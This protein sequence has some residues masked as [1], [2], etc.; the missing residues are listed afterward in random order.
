MTRFWFVLGLAV[1]AAVVVGLAVGLALTGRPGS[2]AVAKDLATARMLDA[3]DTVADREDCTTSADEE[4]RQK[5]SAA[6]ASA[7]A[8]GAAGAAA[9]ARTATAEKAKDAAGAAKARGEA[10]VADAAQVTALADGLTRDPFR[11]GRAAQ[12]DAAIGRLD[13][14]PPDRVVALCVAA[15]RAARGGLPDPA[16]ALAGRLTIPGSRSPCLFADEAVALAKVRGSDYLRAA[17][18]E[19]AQGDDDAARQ[20]AARALEADSSLSAA[21]DALTD[22]AADDDS[23]LDDV[24]EGVAAFPDW[25]GD[26]WPALTA[27]AIGALLLAAL[28]FWLLQGVIAG[29]P[30]PGTRLV[31]RLDRLYVR[32]GGFA[33]G[34][35]GD[36]LTG[37]DV[38]ALLRCGLAPAA[39]RFSYD[40]LPATPPGSRL[41]DI[42]TFL[43]AVP[44]GGLVSAALKLMPSLFAPRT[45]VVSGR[46]V[47]ADVRGAGLAIEVTSPE[48]TFDDIV[49]R[50]RRFDP[51]PE[52]TP[53]EQQGRL[54]AP[55]AVWIRHRLAPAPRDGD[56][57]KA[58]AARLDA[59]MLTAAGEEFS[60]AGDLRRAASCYQRALEGDEAFVPAW[61][62]LA[63]CRLRLGEHAAAVAD[64]RALKE[65]LRVD[66]D[67]CKA[68]PNAL[69]ATRYNLA[70]AEV[71]AA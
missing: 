6:F 19:R 49:L 69:N 8:D 42:A 27:G 67:A 70:L 3:A 51:T 43:S 38:A 5:A 13:N 32:V 10:A 68:W 39:A 65:H 33:G 35:G 54:I 36:G 64:L 55:A 58:A 59:E 57:A 26:A 62:N 60:A 63:V 37:D 30:V 44:H 47:P 14:V 11:A 50:N 45:A 71:Y 21:H 52:G 31:R 46:L 61:F 56:D 40:R 1:A 20:A 4:L 2:C 41:T 15:T 53:A 29:R 23:H 9:R 25:L 24:V 18:H 17:A 34:G 66:Q 16:A 7:D 48:G 22:V 12:L 28:A